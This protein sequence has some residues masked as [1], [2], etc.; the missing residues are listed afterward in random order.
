MPLALTG[1]NEWKQENKRSPRAENRP[2]HSGAAKVGPN[3]LKFQMDA[4]VHSTPRCRTFTFSVNFG[5]TCGHVP[6]RFAK[7]ADMPMLQRRIWRWV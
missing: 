6:A 7:R 3:S 4:K 1:M 2:Y 5:Q